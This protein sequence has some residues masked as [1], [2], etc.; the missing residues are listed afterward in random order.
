MTDL[1]MD[2]T[3]TRDGLVILTLK[4]AAGK[5]YEVKLNSIDVASLMG[6]LQIS[7]EAAM[8]HPM[9][10]SHGM[11]SMKRVQYIEMPEKVFF[12]VFLTDRLFHEYPVPRDTTSAAE[13]KL[14]GDRVEARNMAKAT[15][16]PPDIPDRRN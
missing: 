13:L 9:A 15:H 3:D 10:Q 1:T 12:R 2:N 5:A 14:F 6:S 16:Q 4:D 11:P 8:T 7:V